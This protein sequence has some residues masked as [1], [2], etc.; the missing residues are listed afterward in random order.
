[1][2]CCSAWNCR[3]GTPDAPVSCEDGVEKCLEY[4]D[5]MCGI[6]YS[7]VEQAFFCSVDHPPSWP[8]VLQV[9]HVLCI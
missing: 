9:S 7:D 1:M 5:T 3:R 4:N 8:P 6:A 2:Q